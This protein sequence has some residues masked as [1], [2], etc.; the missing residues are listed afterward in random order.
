MGF[1]HMVAENFMVR[2]YYIAQKFVD[3]GN[4]LRSGLNH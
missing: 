2:A 4:P 3:E 1:D